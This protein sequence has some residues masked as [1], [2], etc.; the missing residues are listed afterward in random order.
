MSRWRL[1]SPGGDIMTILSIAMGLNQ[2]YFFDK[3]PAWQ[4]NESIRRTIM[5][6]QKKFWILVAVYL[7]DLGLIWL[8]IIVVIKKLL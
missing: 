1:L 4:H 5:A 8:L 3:N 6:I 7:I 2:K